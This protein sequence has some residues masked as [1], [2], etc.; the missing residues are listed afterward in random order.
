MMTR[1]DGRVASGAVG[2][3]VT[4]E[5][6]DRHVEGSGLTR[7]L[8]L[9]LLGGAA[10]AACSPT[11]RPSGGDTLL[12]APTGPA[13]SGEVL[14]TGTVR[15]ALLLPKTAP[16]NG[17]T[18][19]AAMQNAAS[20][21]LSDFSGNDLTVLVKD[22]RGS[23]EGAAEAA[24]QAI[25]EGAELIIGPIF[26]AEVGGVG[27]V[28][29]AASVPVI[30]FSS[31]PSVAAS[32]VYILGFLVDGQVR[33]VVAEAARSGRKSIAAI[34]SQSAFGNL[35]EAALR[36]EAGRYGMRVVAVE[37]FAAGGE[38]QS[39][40]AIAAVASQIDCLLLPEGA[41]VAPT[42]ARSLRTAG[43]D[44]SRIKLLGT[45]V[46]NDPSV[47]N[48]P[49]LTGGWF[50]SPEISGFSAFASRYRSTYGGEPPLTAS[51]AY[52]AVVLAAGLAK[53]AGAQRFQL[54]VITNPEGF[55]SSV[56]GLFRFNAFGTNDRGLAVYEVT[57]STPSLV[58]AAP[59]AFTGA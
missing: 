53:T 58:S 28:A 32:G 20:L 34:M 46:W 29:R 43:V 49:A 22:T 10:L 42:I 6:S 35:A 12:P 4:T 13:I 47:Y 26:A 11:S 17:A 33:R 30:A 45:G 25:S 18:L 24:R 3:A 9:L 23:A 50:P 2:F 19:A 56:N 14:G 41:G 39:V 52:D 44:L 57:G 59:R 7:R 5:A 27:P 55:L 48:D 8:A 40:A 15:V 36:Q 38:A 1:D 37:R 16:G 51:L 31:D 21:G 54:S